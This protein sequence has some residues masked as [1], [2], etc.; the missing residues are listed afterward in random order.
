MQGK[1]YQAMKVK[2][3]AA[4]ERAVLIIKTVAIPLVLAAVL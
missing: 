3:I 1:R 2:K 4:K